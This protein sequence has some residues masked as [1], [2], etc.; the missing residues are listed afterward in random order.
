M[1]DDAW[2]LKR[3]QAIETAFRTGRPVFA[4][5]EG[6]Y[7]FTDGSREQP[8]DEIAELPIPELSM[9][10]PPTWWACVRRWLFTP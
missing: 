3:K 7:H 8:S 5:S 2:E 9:S 4:D 6:A 1:T 10:R